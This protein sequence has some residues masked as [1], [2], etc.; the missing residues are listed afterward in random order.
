MP[1]VTV[2]TAA[3]NATRFLPEAMASIV[4]QTFT[5]WHHVVVDDGS[6]DDTAALVRD[7]A[8]RD[9]RVELISLPKSIGPYAAANI[10]LMRACSEYVARLDADD[11]AL[12]G[13]LARQVAALDESGRAASAGTWQALG[14]NGI[15]DR[16]RHVPTNHTGVL[17]WMLCLRGGPLHS[18][19]VARTE[20]FQGIG[21]YGAERIGEDYRLF[22]R[23]ARERQLTLVRDPLV[24][25]RF[26]EGQITAQADGK[27]DEAARLRVRLEHLHACAGPNWSAD[28]ARDLRYVGDGN[29]RFPVG[30]ALDLFRRWES[31]WQADPDL[32]DAER[33]ELGVH[34][35]RVYIQHLWSARRRHPLGTAGAA[36]T[37]APRLGRAI[38]QVRRAPDVRW[39]TG[40]RSAASA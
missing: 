6:T 14:P 9:D 20:W 17:K 1:R 5:D 37:H 13:R 22:C 39:R 31:A 24:L 40:A 8:A 26:H 10:A 12:P 29:A 19:L 33:H 34:A 4:A 28:D 38:V 36:L 25:Y 32:T 16:L 23:A 18:T 30:H 15:D 21:G 27:R 11:V 3:K 2:I 35:S 7:L